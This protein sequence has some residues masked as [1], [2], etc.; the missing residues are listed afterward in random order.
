[1]NRKARTS[2]LPDVTRVDADDEALLRALLDE[3]GSALLGYAT[4]LTGDRALAE[5]VVQETLVR[6]WRHAA[7]LDPERGPVRPWLFT[8]AKNVV[9]DQ[10]RARQARPAEVGDTALQAV[11]AGDE[12]ERAVETWTV[13]E[14][15]ASLS[16]DHR[17][18]LLETY[19]RGSSVAEAAARLGI[20]AG[21]VKSRAF[22]ALRELKLRLQEQG[23]TA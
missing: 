19:Y 9:I 21:T 1:V 15:L 10:A 4:R 2:V 13:A 11:P 17:A 14:A 12:L 8:V 16:A 5:D 3:H 18:V 22:Y 23:V 20:P 7:K 6:A